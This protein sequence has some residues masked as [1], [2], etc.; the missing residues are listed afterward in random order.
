MYMDTSGSACQIVEDGERAIG[1]NQFYTVRVSVSGVDDSTSL[2]YLVHL[3][4]SMASQP[5]HVCSQI[6][7]TRKIEAAIEKNRVSF[8][9]KFPSSLLSTLPL[10]SLALSH[11]DIMGYNS[12]PIPPCSLLRTNSKT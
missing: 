3:C 9:L 1:D 12:I 7:I 5:E 2:Q 4:I 10:P 6:E 8:T 11:D